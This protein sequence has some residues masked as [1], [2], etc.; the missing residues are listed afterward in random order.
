MAFELT[1]QLNTVAEYD[2]F[3]DLFPQATQVSAAEQL[4][5]KKAL[6][7]E[8]AHL[9]TEQARLNNRRAQEQQ[10]MAGLEARL[11]QAPAQLDDDF[12]AEFVA[13]QASITGLI[14]DIRD[15][16]EHRANKLAT[17]MEKAVSDAEAV[18]D[19]KTLTEDERNRQIQQHW[20]VAKR[21]VYLLRSELYRNTSA[22]KRP[23]LEERHQ[24]IIAKLE[25]IRQALINSHDALI[26]ALQ[27]EFAKTRQTLRD[28]FARLHRDNVLMNQ[29]LQQLVASVNVLHQDLEEVN[30]NLKDIHRSLTDVQATVVKTNAHLSLLH[31]DLDRVRGRL[32][33]LNQDMN[34]GLATQQTLLKAVAGTV[35][36]GFSQLHADMAARESQTAALHQEK[37]ALANRQ[38]SANR[39]IA[40]A[41]EQTHQQSLKQRAL[42]T[43]QLRQSIDSQGKTIVNAQS[44]T[45]KAVEHQTQVTLYNTEQL[46]AS[47]RQTQGLIGQ[48]TQQFAKIAEQRSQSDS[49]GGFGGF[50]KGLVSVA[51]NVF[52][53]G[54]GVIAGALFGV[55]SDV[56]QG[57]DLDEALIGGAKGIVGEHCPPCAPAMDVAEGLVQGKEPGDVLLNVAKNQLGNYCPECTPFVDVA[58]GLLKGEDPLNTLEH[59]AKSQLGDA[60]PECVQVWDTA[61]GLA[62]GVPPEQLITDLVGQQIGQQCP[63]C[64]PAVQ[65][66][67]GVVAG[68]PIETVLQNSIGTQLQTYCP[69]CAPVVDIAQQVVAGESLDHIFGQA[70]TL[71]L[72]QSC[73]ECLP[74]VEV[75]R[76]LANG[77]PPITVLKQA[78]AEPLQTACPSCGTLFEVAED[79]AAGKDITDTLTTA[80]QNQV[81]TVCPECVPAWQTAEKMLQ[82]DDPKTVISALVTDKITEHCPDC[83]PTLD[84]VQQIAQGKNPLEL[85]VETTQRQLAKDC[86]ECGEVLQT[87]IPI[88]QQA[89]FDTQQQVLEHLQSQ[90]Y[91]PHLPEQLSRSL[92]AVLGEMGLQAMPRPPQMQNAFDGLPRFTG[93]RLQFISIDDTLQTQIKQLGLQTGFGKSLPARQPS[94][95]LPVPAPSPKELMETLKKFL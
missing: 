72:S 30:Q 44:L 59:L 70:A 86:P 94:S 57:K 60:C 80:A 31:E 1:S 26:A 62:Q 47:D 42:Q 65:A 74:A 52:L 53:P 10:M 43:A 13:V 3:I 82:G 83:A 20:R 63:D 88:A 14:N 8:T 92:N 84:M 34:Q 7:L 67:Q 87:I 39:R 95:A 18:L 91:N 25:Q 21:Y 71:A 69:E 5:Q 89:A 46:L 50:L 12:W 93:Q 23:R 56:V 81:A 51:A 76:S 66:I 32:I 64:L 54:S 49:G 55:V 68:Q 77:Q 78:V 2:A 38:L 41:L 6:V 35:K 4:A 48:Q 19:D 28:G 33:Q 15:I 58:D 16:R 40:N 36:H 11:A 85:V 79:L 27:D 22:A 17:L 37:L 90:L 9:A 61:K 73:P 29:S 45:L 24:R 75:V